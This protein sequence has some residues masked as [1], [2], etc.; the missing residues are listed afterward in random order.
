[1]LSGVSEEGIGDPQK[2]VEQKCEVLTA[3]SA[4]LSAK[5]FNCIKT[6][7]KNINLLQELVLEVKILLLPIS[8]GVGTSTLLNQFSCQSHLLNQVR[9][10]WQLDTGED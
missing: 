3:L 10:L 4:D 2:E 5:F 9:N 6:A 7:I 8:L 1:M